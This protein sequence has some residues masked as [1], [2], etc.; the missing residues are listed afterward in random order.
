MNSS[1]KGLENEQGTNKQ[2][3]NEI[4]KRYPIFIFNVFK[5]MNLAICRPASYL[6]PFT[7]KNNFDKLIIEQ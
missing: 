1:I 3:Q 5:K 2:N 7:L 4:C 6:F